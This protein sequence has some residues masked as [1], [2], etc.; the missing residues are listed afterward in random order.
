LTTPFGGMT[1]GAG[2]PHT[3]ASSS[4]RL[5]PEVTAPA[6]G[7]QEAVG[8]GESGNN[9]TTGNVTLTFAQPVTQVELRYGNFP[10]SGTDNTGTGQQAYGISTMSFCPLPDISVTKSSAP[11]A[12]TGI[13][14]FNIPGAQVVYTLTVT[15]SGGSTVDSNSS[16]VIDVLPSE[17]SFVNGSYGGAGMPV[18][19]TANGS[20]LTLAAANI[21]YSNN[22][23]ATFTYTPAAGADPNV[24]A[25]RITPQGAMA[26]NSSYTVAFLAQVE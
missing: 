17:M 11:L 1:N 6:V 3:N 4:L 15:N 24:N 2:N 12:T 9:A 25:I 7:I 13:D 20:G 21:S 10:F 19:F 22:G 23:G 16:A 14:R 18:L 26:A 8:I 5:G